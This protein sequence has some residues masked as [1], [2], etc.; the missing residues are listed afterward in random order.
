MTLVFSFSSITKF[1]QLLLP[2][3]LESYMT[4]FK[5]FFLLSFGLLTFSGNAQVFQSEWETALKLSEAQDRLLVLVFAGSDW[6]GPCI[7]LD[8]EVWQDPSFERFAKESLVAYRADFPRKKAN[9]LPDV[10]SATNKKLAA[11]YNPNGYFPLVVILKQG[12]V[13]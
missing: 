2:I 7:K 9:K 12:T 1:F 13:V 3:I 11:A 10:L 4:S 6:C 5:H 8:K